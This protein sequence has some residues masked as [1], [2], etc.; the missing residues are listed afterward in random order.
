MNN[1]FLIPS[2]TQNTDGTRRYG[3]AT[4]TVVSG[5]RTSVFT[6]H[7]SMG[8]M[9]WELPYV[10]PDNKTVYGTCDGTGVG[11]TKFVANTAKDM[12]SGAI[13]PPT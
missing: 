6:K 7:M 5:P 4:E 2:E 8:R 13:V 3:Y 9:S 12:S 11:F 1:V 10:M